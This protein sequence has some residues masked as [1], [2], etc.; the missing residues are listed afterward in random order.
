MV[1]ATIGEQVHPLPGT[2]SKLTIVCKSPQLSMNE[3]AYKDGDEKALTLDFT[4]ATY[5]AD[6]VEKL[7]DETVPL[8][9]MIFPTFTWPLARPWPDGVRHIVGL[10]DMTLKITKLKEGKIL[11]AWKYP[12]AFLHPAEQANLA[13]VIIKI[14]EKFKPTT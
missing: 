11:I 8:V 13:D 1:T 12:E 9:Q 2:E 5:H 10:V 14:Y 3:I 4:A 7:D 6:R